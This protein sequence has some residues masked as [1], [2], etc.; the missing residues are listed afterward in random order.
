M[1]E[2]SLKVIYTRMRGNFFIG[3]DLYTQQDLRNIDEAIEKLQ[4]G[5][6]VVSVSY[7]QHT[8]RYADIN[9]AELLNLRQRIRA[10]L[11]TSDEPG[12]SPKLR[13]M[14]F[15]THKGIP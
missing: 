14:H 5:K 15:A 11:K 7:G 9:L 6:R 8:V 3:Y 10:E 2:I 12:A 13:H 1:D 4:L